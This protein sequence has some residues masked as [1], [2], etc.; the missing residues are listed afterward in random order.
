[1]NLHLF[2][3]RD[4]TRRAGGY[5]AMADIFLSY[6]NEDRETAAQLARLLESVGWRVW[7]DRR[8]PAGRTWRTVLETAL[9]DMRCMIVLWS[10]QSVNSPWVAEEAEEARKL[11]KML[12][13]VLIDRVEP[14]MGFRAIQAADL[15]NWDGTIDDPAA[16]MFIADLKSLLKTPADTSDKQSRVFDTPK[17]E[18][19]SA[20][21][22]W[23]SAHWLQGSLAGLAIF[24]LLAGWQKWR[25]SKPAPDPVVGQENQKIEPAPRLI[26][27]A[28]GAER[29]EMKP[30]ESLEMTATAN[31]SDGAKKQLRD[32]LAWTSSDASVATV[33]A[34][35]EVRG[36]KTGATNIT[37]KIGEVVSAAWTIHV[38]AVEPAIAAAKL[39]A[40]DVISSKKELFTGEKVS[41]RTKGRYSDNSEKAVLVGIDWEI[42]DRT[43][44]AVSPGGELEGLRPGKVQ[45]AARSGNLL[46]GPLTFLIKEAQ[47][48]AE[49]QAKQVKFAEPRSI[50]PPPKADS[51]KARII[52]LINRARS[53]REQG[54]YGGAMAEL[55]KAKGYD[56][57]NE[58]VRKE[59]EQTKKAC[60][61]EKVLGNKPIC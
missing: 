3:I 48:P 6:A 15:V 5:W 57:L 47:R 46:S 24:S 59:I 54:N 44:A 43:I 55:E 50:K 42:R 29:T 11:G 8:I 33:N 13:P 34:Q 22:R 49:P 10:Q 30:A 14:P 4:F 9:Q 52:E 35:G 40:L 2:T 23:L 7:W 58:D 17:I 26:T 1:V 27:L 31:Y 39:V 53:Y 45:V 16:R 61:A 19:G 21:F 56:A 37:A 36:L 51:S 41:I 18:S 60:N 38:K 25:D 20:T 32:G 28:V 12:V